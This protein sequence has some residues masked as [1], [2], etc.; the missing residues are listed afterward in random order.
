MIFYFLLEN[1]KMTDLIVERLRESELWTRR[2]LV[3]ALFH[4]G[5]GY[6]TGNKVQHG[7]S[8]RVKHGGRGNEKR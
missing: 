4:C 3:L 7:E 2:G 1:Y 8:A 5:L 6:V